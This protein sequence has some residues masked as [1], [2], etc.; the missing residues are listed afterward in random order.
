[1]T[2]GH[3]AEVSTW[4]AGVTRVIL[5]VLQVQLA[6]VQLLHDSGHIASNQLQGAGRGLGLLQHG[7]HAVWSLGLTWRDGHGGQSST[8]R[9][10]RR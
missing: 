4:G 3:H 6:G 2:S 1:M 7:Q 8:Q 5:A 9:R 10:W